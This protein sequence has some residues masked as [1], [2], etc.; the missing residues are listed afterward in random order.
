MSTETKVT[1]L[2]CMYSGSPSWKTSMEI[3]PGLDPNSGQVLL[4][5]EPLELWHW[6][7]LDGIY[8][9]TQF[10]SQAGSFLGFNSA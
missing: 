4:P 6:S 1:N 9:W 5:T 7:R 8:P 10:D 2:A 3:Q